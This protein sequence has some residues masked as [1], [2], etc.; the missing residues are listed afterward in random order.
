MHILLSF[1]LSFL[2]FFARLTLLFWILIILVIG[3]PYLICPVYRFPEKQP[4]SGTAWYNPYA[5]LAPFW[6][7]SNF[8]CHSKS[9]K[10]M[11]NGVNTIPEI[12][13]YY[14]SLGYDCICL[15]N[16]QHITPPDSSGMHP[17]GVYEHGYNLW[18]RHH[19]VIGASHVEW[20][21]FLLWQS[22]HQKQFILKCLKGDGFIAIAHPRFAG[23]F[24]ESDIAALTDFDAVEA[25]NSYRDSPDHWDAALSAGNPVWLLGSDDSHNIANTRQTGTR[26]NMINAGSKSPDALLSALRS[27]RYYAVVGRMGKMDNRLISAVS[28]SAGYRISFESPVHQ[29]IFTGMH[30]DTLADFSNIRQ[31]VFHPDSGSHYVRVSA[32]TSECSFFLNPLIR[33]DGSTLPAYKATLN[34]PL[35]LLK[36]YLSLVA[37]LLMGITILKVKKR[38]RN[39]HLHRQSP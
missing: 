33:Y 34:W 39:R 25:F 7:K 28:D 21:D 35:S 9:W 8:H 17:L 29:M 22:L 14:R 15:S 5:S 16:Y 11:T 6:Y 32:F 37:I 31:A 12:Y 18:K 30:G 10:G 36:Y 3:I 27:G 1:F 24:S 20:L 38:M 4:F 13:A 19:I 23:G 2:K 26:W